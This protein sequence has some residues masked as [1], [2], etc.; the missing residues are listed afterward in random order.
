MV[1]LQDDLF[2]KMRPPSFIIIAH[3][4]TERISRVGTNLLE[5]LGSCSFHV[6]YIRTPVIVQYIR[7]ALDIT[8]KNKIYLCVYTFLLLLVILPWVVAFRME[9]SLLHDAYLDLLTNTTD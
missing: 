2:K 1:L 3:T 4:I 9:E 7:K 8:T 5:I 6:F